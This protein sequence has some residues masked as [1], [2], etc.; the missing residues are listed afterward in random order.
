M[1]FA[2]VYYTGDGETTNFAI[3]FPYIK[4]DHLHVLV[5]N[6]GELS[7]AVTTWSLNS[8]SI[9]AITTAPTLEASVLI[10][11]ETPK[12]TRIVQYSDNSYLT[13][14]DMDMDS[15]Q[16]FFVMQELSDLFGVTSGE[17]N[18]AAEI[19]SSASMAA[20]LAATAAAEAVALVGTFTNTIN[21]A[22]A[23]ASGT[24]TAALSAAL[25]AQ[26]AAEAAAADAADISLAVEDSSHGHANKSVID[27]FTESTEG[28]LLYNGGGF[29]QASDIDELLD[30]IDSLAVQTSFL[31]PLKTVGVPQESVGATL[32]KFKRNEMSA[33]T[34]G[35]FYLPVCDAD[36]WVELRLVPGAGLH[37]LDFKTVAGRA[38]GKPDGTT[39][40]TSTYVATEY[41]RSV[42]LV[43]VGTSLFVLEGN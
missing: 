41:N 17:S 16:H 37:T 35:T 11:R 6:R 7:Y 10:Y 12:E 3:P 24:A 26:A 31:Q 23:A 40:D 39:V 2:R 36:E 18:T 30:D 21:E 42:K 19:A 38:L 9:I 29:A 34:A 1:Y 4:K 20:E 14:A 22:A 8:A 5:K 25:A 27:R 33:V 15:T 43:A 32:T 28:Q 13:M